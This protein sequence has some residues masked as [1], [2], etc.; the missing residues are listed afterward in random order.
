METVFIGKSVFDEEKIQI[1]TRYVWQFI[2]KGFIS[3]EFWSYSKLKS[4]ITI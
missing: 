2:K 1:R 3:E 4:K